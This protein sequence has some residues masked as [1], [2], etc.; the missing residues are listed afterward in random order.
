MSTIKQL[1]NILVYTKLNPKSFSEK[2]GLA[3]PQAIYDIQ[4]GKTKNFSHAMINKIISVF[5]EFNKSWLLTG[6]GEMLIEKEKTTST[7]N[8]IKEDLKDRC[9]SLEESV[10]LLKQENELLKKIID[11]TNRIY[12]LENSKHKSKKRSD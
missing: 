3:R 4:K 1:N 10:R 8:L 9:K 6:E 2:I 12:F 7:E 11:L 5:P